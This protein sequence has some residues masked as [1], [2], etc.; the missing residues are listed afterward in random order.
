LSTPDSPDP[1]VE[2][3]DKV[4]FAMGADQIPSRPKIEGIEKFK[5]FVEHSMS[6]KE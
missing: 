1:K 3:F 5:G 6:F 2:Y 4:V